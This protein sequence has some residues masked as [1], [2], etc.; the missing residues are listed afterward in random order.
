MIKLSPISLLLLFTPYVYANALYLQA[1]EN[2]N[3]NIDFSLLLNENFL[4]GTYNITIYINNNKKQNAEISFKNKNN[5]LTPIITLFDLKQWGINT[6]YYEPLKNKLDN[7]IVD[8]DLLKKLF[9]IKLEINKQSIYFKVPLIA[10]EKNTSYSKEKLDDGD[11]AAFIKYNYQGH[12]YKQN[13]L[14]GQHIH[15]LQLYNGINLFAWRYR[16]DLNYNNNN[17]FSINQQYVYRTLRNINSILTMGDFYAYS[18]NL[19]TYK[20]LGV[21][22]NSDNAMKDGSLVGYA[23]IISETAYTY[24]EV[25]IE[26]NGETLY[27]TSVPPGPFTLNNLPSLGTNGELVLIIKE[28]NGEVRKKKIWNYSSQYLLRNNQWNYYY[29]MG[30]VNNPQKRQFPSNKKKELLTQLNL[31]YGVSN[32]LTTMIG[33]EKKGDDIKALIGN[34]LGLNILGIVSLENA[35]IREKY[36]QQYQSNKINYQK[37]FSMENTTISL[38]SSF[39]FRFKENYAVNKEYKKYDL[40][41]HFS[42]SLNNNIALTLGYNIATYYHSKEKSQRLF[43]NTSSN[44]KKLSY[45]LEL[46]NSKDQYSNNNQLSIFLNY[47]IGQDLSH[48][49]TARINYDNREKYFHENISFSGNTLENNRL[50]Y[51]L[52][53]SKNN[54][55]RLDSSM[56]INYL[57]RIAKLNINS[58]FNKDSYSLGYGLNGGIVF[59]NGGITLAQDLNDSF[60]ILNF[61]GAKKVKIIGKPTIESDRRGYL[62]IPNLTS[63]HNNKFHIDAKSLDYNYNIDNYSYHLIPTKGA[64]IAKNIKVTKGESALFTFHQNI[65]FGA[66]AYVKNSDGTLSDISYV[67]EDNKLY[68]SNLPISGKIFVK[69]GSSNKQQCSFNYQLND[70]EKQNR[71]YFKTVNCIKEE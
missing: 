68:I 60:A 2:H 62:I 36:H 57:S 21:Q 16:Q 64:I 11:N 25:S 30:L 40:G 65:P 22:I 24:A 17:S 26:Q 63:Y 53:F 38:N 4:E 44:Y 49:A 48:W 45:S 61:A 3:G 31:S 33:A 66:T 6:N 14:N 35:W 10:I 47:P 28:E 69:W 34:T 27:S 51:N 18:P 56:K 7:D 1:I 42:Q 12:Y 32:Y 39:Y 19:N 23:P 71:I 58:R 41:F 54:K 43:I 9:N 67:N 13:S 29:T 59:H 52:D 46:E 8:Y 70:N 50:N 15:N 37:V 5:N 55:E 20:I